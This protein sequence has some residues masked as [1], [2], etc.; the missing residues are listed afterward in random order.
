MF[1][2]EGKTVLI[3]GASSGIGEQLAKQF[4]KLNCSL[5]LVAR[6]V[7][8]LEAIALECR[9]WTSREVVVYSTDLQDSIERKQFLQQLPKHSVDI[10]INNAGYGL[11]KEVHEFQ[12]NEVYD[13]FELNVM[14]LIELT[15][16]FSKEMKERKNGVIVQVASQAGKMAT[17]KSTIYSASKFAVIGFSN[18]LRL[19][20]APFG[21]RVLTVNPGPIKTRFF[22]RAEP[23]G[24]YLK[25]LGSYVLDAEYVAKKIISG[26]QQQK[27]EVNLPFS[28]HVGSVLYTMF[29]KIGDYLTSQI[30]NKK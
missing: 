11:L 30:F 21:V 22:E 28:M 23:T 27:R 19:E 9:Q 7:K 29:P 10:L 20:M 16:H 12:M 13:L 14:A 17:A 2:M 18:A 5:I 15:M 1:N 24:N 4:A 25:A 3:T 26:I 6:N 8:R